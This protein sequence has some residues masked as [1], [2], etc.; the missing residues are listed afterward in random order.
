MFNGTLRALLCSLHPH[1]K[2]RLN[3]PVENTPSLCIVQRMGDFSILTG[4]LMVLVSFKRKRAATRTWTP[5][6]GSTD[7]HTLWKWCKFD[8]HTNHWANLKITR[9]NAS[10]SQS[11]SMEDI[12]M[13]LFSISGALPPRT[14]HLWTYFQLT[15][16]VLKLPW[17][18]RAALSIT[19]SLWS[20]R[21][22]INM[23]FNYVSIFLGV[24]L[25]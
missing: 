18:S 3:S 24:L 9:A 13:N 17:G 19:C 16:L 11:S 1:E 15:D 14:K 10:M 12:K 21:T 25:F 7:T 5:Q 2:T 4:L 20:Y 22:K 23:Q 8:L 6:R